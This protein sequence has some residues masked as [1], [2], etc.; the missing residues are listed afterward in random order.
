MGFKKKPVKQLKHNIFLMRIVM[1]P[2]N[3]QQIAGILYFL[4]ASSWGLY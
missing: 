1:Q 3:L 4:P 2:K